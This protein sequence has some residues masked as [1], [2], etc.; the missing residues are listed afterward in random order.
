MHICI[1][2]PD[3]CGLIS[4][5]ALSIWLIIHYTYTDASPVSF[6]DEAKGKYRGIEG[7]WNYSHNGWRFNI[8]QSFFQSE[9]DVSDE[10][11]EPGRYNGQYATH[12]SIA[13]E[14]IREK[15]GKARIWNFSM[16]GMLHG[17]LWEEQI[18]VDASAQYYT[19]P[20]QALR[21]F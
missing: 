4:L 7:Q 13:K 6:T 14:L 21:C 1:P 8:N 20:L 15:N 2:C 5:K 12:L 9:R 3:S 18:D 17:G 16:R 11:L 19:N 10:S